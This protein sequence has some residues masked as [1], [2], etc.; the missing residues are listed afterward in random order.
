MMQTKYGDPIEYALLLDALRIP[1]NE[2]LGRSILLDFTGVV[3][4]VT[5]NRKVRKTYNDG[6][7]WPCTQTLARC[8]LCIVKPETCHY[9]KG[10]CREPAWGEKHCMSPHFVYL[11]N[12]TGIKVGITRG[13]NLPFRWIDQ[14]AYQAIPVMEVQ[15]RYHSGLM[16]M[17]FK[18]YVNDRTDWRKMLK[19]E[20]ASIDLPTERRGLLAKCA[21]SIERFREQHG[22]DSVRLIEAEEVTTLRYPVLR[23]PS[24]ISSLNPSK[25]PKIEGRLLGIKGQY[26]ILSSGVL[27][28]RK[29]MGREVA[30]SV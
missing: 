24:K 25:T 4:C 11:A 18:Q 5:C 2:Y 21:Q 26:L 6:H 13:T 7:C 30:F 3:R 22:S 8:D 10:T 28:I 27:N 19:N 14:G 15:T 16:E 12:S 29:W 17:M 23:Y 9:H 1:L 20:V